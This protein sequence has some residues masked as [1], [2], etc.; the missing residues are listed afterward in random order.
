M[1]NSDIKRQRL[2]KT[3]E[4]RGI[5]PE[6][7]SIDELINILQKRGITDQS[8]ND[9]IWRLLSTL[10]PP[11]CDMGHCAEYGGQAFFCQCR[12][13]KVPGRCS[14]Y[15]AYTKRK[16]GKLAKNSA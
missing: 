4:Y 7:F 10:E 15:K 2:R 3:L 11:M 1:W 14:I 13:E 16:K 5:N 8:L 6:S 12:S 9:I